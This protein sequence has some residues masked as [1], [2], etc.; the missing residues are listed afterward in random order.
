MI[1]I[2]IKKI[3]NVYPISNPQL[4]LN[5]VEHKKCFVCFVSYKKKKTWVILKF[6]NYSKYIFNDEKKNENKN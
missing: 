2:D 1:D 3:I 6:I 4:S 5:F